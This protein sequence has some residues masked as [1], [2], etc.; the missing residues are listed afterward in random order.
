MPK[1]FEDL[2]TFQRA[3]E[4]SVAVYEATAHFPIE[5]RY[6]LKK[7][8]RN[9]STSIVS[10]IAEGQ[11]R[12]TNGEWRQFL[13]QARGSLFE[14]QAQL[15]IARRLGYLDDAAYRRLRSSVIRAAKPL[16][17]LIRYVQ[18]R[19]IEKRKLTTDNRQR[20]PKAR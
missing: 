20:A 8:L 9:A 4:L 5:E 6:R 11:G 2:E 14:V 19:E 7:Q 1:N 17:G 16:A 18:R 15:L 10:N 12:L 3:V 13:S